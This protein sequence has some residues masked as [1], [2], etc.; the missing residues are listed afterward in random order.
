MSSSSEPGSTS[1][2][3][4]TQGASYTDS[5]APEGSNSKIVGTV[6]GV[7]VGSLFLVAAVTTAIILARKRA[8]GVQPEVELS[9][10]KTRSAR[11][12]SVNIETSEFIRELENVRVKSKLGAGSMM[13]SSVTDSF[14]VIWRCVFGILEWNCCSSQE[15][16]GQQC[17]HAVQKRSKHAIVSKQIGN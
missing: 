6:V 1:Y 3:T 7:V 12:L 5:R 11:V 17:C 16:E 13:P 4:G 15:V 10:T 8:K 14:R 9:T 2:A